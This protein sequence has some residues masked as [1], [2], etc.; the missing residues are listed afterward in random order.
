ML[1]PRLCGFVIPALFILGDSSAD[2]G[3]NSFLT[4]SQAS[5]NFFFLL[6]KQELT[7][8]PMASIF[9]TQGPPGGSGMVLTMLITLPS[10][11]DSGE[12]RSNFSILQ[13]SNQDSLT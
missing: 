10:L 2:V 11:W 13:P 4:D 3:T 8:R 5:A 9:Q 12:A 7:F 1:V 6:N